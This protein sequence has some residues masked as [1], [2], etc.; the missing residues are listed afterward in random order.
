[1]PGL[2]LYIVPTDRCPP[3]TCA[4]SSWLRALGSA[5]GAIF[6]SLLFVVFDIFFSPLIL[7]FFILFS[8]RSLHYRF[9]HTC[10]ACLRNR[11]SWKDFLQ[12]IANPQRDAIPPY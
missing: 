9:T 2:V 12:R 4:S 5:C 11:S 7:L 10:A 8:R 1:M 6:V 3:D